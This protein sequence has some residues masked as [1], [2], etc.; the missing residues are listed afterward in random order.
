MRASGVEPVRLH[1][2]FRGDDHGGG[3]VV[4]AGGVAGG[5]RAVV[6]ERRLQLGELLERGVRPRML[7]LVDQ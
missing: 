7:V 3:A 2:R 5:H 4:D 1:R 6:A